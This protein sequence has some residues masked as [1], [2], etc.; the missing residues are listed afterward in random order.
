MVGKIER[1]KDAAQEVVEST[2]VH[3][4]RIATIIAQAV[5]DVTREIGDIVTDGFE[6]REAARRAGRDDPDDGARWRHRRAARRA[7]SVES[8]DA[9]P[10]ADAVEPHADA[11]ESDAGAAKPGSDAD[12]GEAEPDAG[13]PPR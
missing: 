10:D 12:P 5:A 6:M 2:A 4:G 7:G 1:N 8:D 13:D 3:V 11:V 9:E